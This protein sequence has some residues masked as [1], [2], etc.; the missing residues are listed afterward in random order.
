MR[1]RS[2]ESGIQSGRPIAGSRGPAERRRIGEVMN[3]DP[4]MGNQIVVRQAETGKLFGETAI[5][6]GVASEEEVRRAIEEQ[7]GYAILEEGDSRLDPLVVMAFHSDDPLAQTARDLR[8]SIT[9]SRLGEGHPIQTVALV[10]LATGTA[11]SVL[12]ANLAVA[13]A[14][15]GNRT[16]LV[17]ANI[18]SPQQH[19]LFRLSNRTGVSTLL[20]TGAMSDELTRPTVIPLLSVMTAG[21]SVPNAP[22]LLDRQRL[23]QA[24]DPFREGFDLIVV[25]AAHAGEGGLD[26]CYGLDAA[27]VVLTRGV[28]ETRVM[29]DAIDLLHE[30]GVAVLGTVL[31][32]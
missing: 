2:S 28:S 11:C 1:L 23:A 17:D 24:I 12:T 15:S 19:A 29:R 6:M 20:S 5:E 10:G 22:E 16:L 31:T 26:P 7:Q 13:C 8:S 14:Q 3:V 9:G 21:P 32:D 18:R 27:I 25:D 4:S 30:Q